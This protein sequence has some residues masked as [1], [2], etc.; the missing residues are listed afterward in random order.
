MNW[1][2]RDA[3][4]TKSPVI[5]GI[6]VSCLAAPAN[7]TDQAPTSARPT[8]SW[9]GNGQ[10]TAESARAQ[11]PYLLHDY[12][13]ELKLTSFVNLLEGN[14]QA[15]FSYSGGDD[16]VIASSSGPDAV[17]LED[18]WTDPSLQK[19]TMAGYK[20]VEDPGRVRLFKT[21][22]GELIAGF[23]PCP[24]LLSASSF[25]DLFIEDMTNARG[26]LSPISIEECSGAKVG[27]S[28]AV[29]DDECSEGFRQ[30]F[31]RTDD[32]LANL[33]KTQAIQTLALWQNATPCPS[34][35]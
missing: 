7:N 14:P 18:V 1:S 26:K 16:V 32:T 12:L 15:A 34:L 8:Q 35:L 25:G 22:S 9:R 21:A 28:L 31:V 10:H 2:S 20:L 23:I 30:V 6:H 19:F 13:S 24:G 11:F 4:Y 3:E 27:T 17:E 5:V 33:S 29:Y